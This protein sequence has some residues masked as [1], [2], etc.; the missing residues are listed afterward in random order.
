MVVHEFIPFLSCYPSP[1]SFMVTSAY[2]KR[3]DVKLNHA[4]R[5]AL[6]IRIEFVFPISTYD[7]DTHASSEF[8]S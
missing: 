4:H 5:L 2:L 1:F 3:S 8:D 6:C 7:A